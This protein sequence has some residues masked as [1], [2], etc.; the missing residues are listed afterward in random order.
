MSEFDRYHARSIKN[1]ILAEN[2]HTFIRIE[3]GNLILKSDNLT[4]KQRELVINFKD[5]LITL[6]KTP[7]AGVAPCNN[8]K[9]PI[10]WICN[11]YGDWVCSCYRRDQLL[12]MTTLYTFGYLKTSVKRTLAEL[13][14]MSI[15]VI[16]VR[17]KPHSSHWEWTQASLRDSLG[18][19]Y[20]HIPDLGN[21]LFHTALTGQFTEPKIKIHNIDRG[22]KQ[23]KDILDRQRRAAIFCACTGK[24][25]HRFEV[26]EQAAA[27]VPELKIM[28]L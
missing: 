19:L 21:E 15:A 6:L 13:K 28:H 22:L 20:H 7:P 9:K 11:K 8:C 1:A 23:L 14:K 26:A 5:E 18:S 27:V 16:D 3:K 25:C 24:N 4:P 10:E 17:F 12:N 2:P